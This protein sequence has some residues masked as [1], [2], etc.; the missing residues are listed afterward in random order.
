MIISKRHMRR[1]HWGLKDSFGITTKART[2]SQKSIKNAIGVFQL[3]HRHRGFREPFL[4]DGTAQSTR[5]ARM[6]MRLCRVQILEPNH[7]T[8]LHTLRQIC[9]KIFQLF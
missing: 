4:S 6:I 2:I 1:G 7:G 8:G 3:L 9:P 5:P